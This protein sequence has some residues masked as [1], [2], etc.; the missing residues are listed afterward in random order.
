MVLYHITKEKHLSSIA[1]EGLSVNR[2]LGLGRYGR[3]ERI[4]AVWLTD[5]PKHIIETQIGENTFDRS[6]WVILTVMVDGLDWCRAMYRAREERYSFAFYE[7]E[8]WC[9]DIPS[10]RIDFN[11]TVRL[12]RVK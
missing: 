6:D 4:K 9:Q 11:K 1:I 7:H 12:N 5:C 2:L 8:F 10:E 3:R